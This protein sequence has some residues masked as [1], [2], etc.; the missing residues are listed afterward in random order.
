MRIALQVEYDGTAYAGWQRQKNATTVQEEIERA[1]Q[2]VTGVFASVAGAGRTDAGVHALGQWAQF[3]TDSSIPPEKFSY[4]LNRVLPED[5]RI[6][7]SR[8][9]PPGFHVIRDAQRKHYRY[10]VYL[11]LIHI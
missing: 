3:D 10:T 1:I 8:A 5:I 6:R 9:V 2:R 11:S 4:A 7:T